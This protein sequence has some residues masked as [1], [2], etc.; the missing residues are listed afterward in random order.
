[1]NER[2]EPRAQVA[3]RPPVAVRP[4]LGRHRCPVCDGVVPPGTG[5]MTRY[6]GMTLVFRGTECRSCFERD[7]ERYLQVL[8]T[9][10][11]ARQQDADT[12]PASE[13]CCY[14]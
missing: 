14:R 13:W 12:S 9:E 1:M 4:F 11:E 7:S 10:P 5:V 3:V 8:V 2:A 6:E